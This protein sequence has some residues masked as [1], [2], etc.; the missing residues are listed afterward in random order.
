[1]EEGETDARNFPDKIKLHSTRSAV[2]A[3]AKIEN[4]YF[5]EHV[6]LLMCNY[7]ICICTS[8]NIIELF[9]FLFLIIKLEELEEDLSLGK[10]INHHEFR[11]HQVIVLKNIVKS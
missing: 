1:M 11:F 4:H 8:F 10:F 7:V 6:I 9:F 3:I 2:D 5:N